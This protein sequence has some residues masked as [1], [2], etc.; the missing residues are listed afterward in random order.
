MHHRLVAI[1]LCIFASA[2]GAQCVAPVS[3]DAKAGA[4]VIKVAPLAKAAP[5]A[6]TGGEL[7]KSAAAGT[8]DEPGAPL[9]HAVLVQGAPP[10]HD[11][12]EHP[13]RSGTAML[14]AALALMSGIA[15]RRSSS[16]HQ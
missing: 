11:T 13:R 1:V 2:A 14:L 5:A 7:I 15:L 9:Q 16:H 4:G 12:P 3:T 8:R 10:L 6:H